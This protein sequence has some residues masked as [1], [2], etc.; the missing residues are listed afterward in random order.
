MVRGRRIH[1]ENVHTVVQTQTGADGTHVWPFDPRFPVDVRFF[2]IGARHGTRLSRHDYFELLYMSSGQAIYRVH[3]RLVRVREND[4]FVINGA[5]YHGVHQL[6]SPPVKI[7]VLYFLP[8]LVR[9][10]GPAHE[11][12][13]YL[14]PF[15]A[16]DDDF[17]SLIRAETHIPAQILD[18]MKRVHAELP[19]TSERARLCVITYLK[20]ILV[21]LVNHYTA[22]QGSAGTLARKQEA[23]RRLRPLFKL[24]EERLDQ[25]ITLRDAA[26]ATGMSR[27]HFTRFFKGVTG[28]T[29]VTYLN[30]FRIAKAQELLASTQSSIAEVAQAVGF[31]DQSYFGLLF[32]RLVRMAPLQYRRSCFESKDSPSAHGLKEGSP[33]KGG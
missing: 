4:L 33:I 1:W 6:L 23:L 19:A 24:I 32:R 7:A 21:L 12:D 14:M 26:E 8:K 20:M 3:D 25:R 17:P 31:C 11:S 18:L 15:L 22:Y 29:F 10:A 9:A 16:Q 13:Q 30:D 5:S 2:A 28:Q 27:A